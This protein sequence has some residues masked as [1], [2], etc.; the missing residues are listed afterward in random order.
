MTQ[1][2]LQCLGILGDRFSPE[3]EDEASVAAMTTSLMFVVSLQ[4]KQMI[5]PLFSIIN[6]QY[7]HKLTS[8]LL[9]NYTDFNT[10]NL[11]I[12]NG[13]CMVDINNI[14]HSKVGTSLL[15]L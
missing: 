1:F 9:Q 7:S 8:N 12:H 15:W 6:F 14:L 2:S 3:R 10:H 11:Y 5:T 4:H 13:N